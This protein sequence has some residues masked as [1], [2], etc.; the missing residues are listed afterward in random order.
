MCTGRAGRAGRR[1]PRG[2]RACRGAATA[3][4]RRA[5]RGC[6]AGRG[7]GCG[8]RGGGAVARR[9][10]RRS[11]SGG[12]ACAA[13]AV[14]RGAQG[15]HCGGAPCLAAAAL[16][17][18]DA[19]SAAP[20]L[21]GAEPGPSRLTVSVARARD[22]RLCAARSLPQPQNIDKPGSPY[23]LYAKKRTEYTMAQYNSLRA[24]LASAT[25][26][27]QPN[28]P[29]QFRRAH[30]AHSWRAPLTQPSARA[31]LGPRAPRGSR[32]P[33]SS[34]PGCTR[35]PSTSTRCRLG[36]VAVPLFT[37]A[38]PLHF[39]ITNIFG[40]SVYEA[41]MRPNPLGAGRLPVLLVDRAPG[42]RD[43]RGPGARAD[44]RGGRRRVHGRRWRQRLGECVPAASNVTLEGAAGASAEARQRFGGSR[45]GR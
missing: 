41:T 6:G 28:Q 23:N 11:C 43:A 44:C 22:T 19:P 38:H 2:R 8:Q 36:S 29:C 40:A 31:G 21:H 17:A 35:S 14:L 12:G 16:A 39:K 32:R 42:L 7:P 18:E 13:G 26:L 30:P 45:R 33:P 1:P 20:R 15:G 4:R 3:G 5:R 37:T 34:P 10:P 25:E 27:D 9:G 24:V